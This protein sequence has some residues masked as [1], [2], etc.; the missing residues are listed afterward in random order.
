VAFPDDVLADG[1]QVV[2]NTHPHWSRL[3]VPAL[4][5]PAVLLCAVVGVFLVPTWPV[6]DA[7][8]YVIIAA[9]LGA[10]GYYSVLPWFRWVTTRYVVTTQRLLVG[11]GFAG[12][13]SS[14][15]I[16]LSRIEKASFRSAFV[17]RFLGC[18]TLVVSVAGQRGP[19]V[20][21]SVPDVED[22]SLLLYQLGEDAGR[23]V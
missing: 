22:V 16:R 18:G 17:E 9:A 15:D 11:E 14:R 4:A 8:Q 23:R 10:L 21:S 7:I 12:S 19:F 2:V 3:A 6:Q 1:E 13:R 20:L 5:V